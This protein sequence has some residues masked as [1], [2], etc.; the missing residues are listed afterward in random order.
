MR[1]ARLLFWAAALALP[2]AAES[3]PQIAGL[4]RD[5]RLDEVSGMARSAYSPQ[6]LWLH[7]D[8]GTRAQLFA[9]DTTGRLQASLTIEGVKPVDWEDM[10]AFRLDG[11]AYLL[12]ADVGDN[13][14]VRARSELVV[15]EEPPFEPADS[16]RTLST[17]PAWRIAFRYADEPHDVEAVGVDATSQTVLLLTKRTDPPQL[18]SLPLRPADGQV[19]VA[20]LLGDIAVPQEATPTVNFRRRLQPGRPTGLTISADGRSAAVLTYAS[21]WLFRRGEGQDWAQAFATLPQVF[22]LGLVPQAEAITFGAEANTLY[23]TGEHW[24]APLIRLDLP[25]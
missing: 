12:L 8:S 9:V 7:N 19:Q 3:L 24:P 2:A 14:G 11:R 1:R 10:A 22:P 4:L 16:A 25:P 21:V 5:A 18:W 13:G 15:I 23:I 20:R 6:R 17:K